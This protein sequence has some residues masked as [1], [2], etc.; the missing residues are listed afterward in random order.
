MGE[1]PGMNLNR[2]VQVM[3]ALVAFKPDAD[4]SEIRDVIAD[5]RLGL[6]EFD[7]LVQE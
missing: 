7:A 1:L 3:K 5:L 2:A 6:V 4:M